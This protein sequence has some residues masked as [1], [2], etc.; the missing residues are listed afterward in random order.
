MKDLTAK[1]GLRCAIYTESRPTRGLSRTS[2][3]STPS[4]RRRRPTSRVRRMRAGDQPAITTT[5]GAIRAG[6]W[7]GRPVQKLLGDVQARRVDVIVVYKVDR[8]TRSL[9]DFAKLVEL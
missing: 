3:P 1:R 9:A 5:T 4:G 7:T 8:L 6:R 2:T